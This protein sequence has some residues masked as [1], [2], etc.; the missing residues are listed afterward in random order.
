M[1]AWVIT[2]PSSYAR[3]S[4]GVGEISGSYTRLTPLYV[5][6]QCTRARQRETRLSWG[7]KVKL[8][9]NNEGHKNFKTGEIGEPSDKA[10]RGLT[11]SR[12][13]TDGVTW[14]D[15]TRIMTQQ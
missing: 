2:H 6:R 3:S 5:A 10:S 8:I 13:P 14:E 15:A 1:T 11:R 12:H 9:L 7:A 4:F